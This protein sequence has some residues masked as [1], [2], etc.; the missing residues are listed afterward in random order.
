M[1]N[2]HHQ[3]W[4]TYMCTCAGWDASPNPTLDLPLHVAVI[5]A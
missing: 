1:F 4:R 5:S 2:I 3:A